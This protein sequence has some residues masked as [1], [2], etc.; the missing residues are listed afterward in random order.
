MVKE[1][2]KG[3]ILDSGLSSPSI[4]VSSYLVLGGH[5]MGGIKGGNKKNPQNNKDQL[6]VCIRNQQAWDSP[7]VSG[8]SPLLLMH[9]GCLPVHLFPLWP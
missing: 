2:A 3:K 6:H 5:K 4:L 9:L 1:E 8:A 7:A